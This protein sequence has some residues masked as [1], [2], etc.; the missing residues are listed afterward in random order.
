MPK[1]LNFEDYARAAEEETE[2]YRQQGRLF[3]VKHSP[4]TLCGRCH[5]NPRRPYHAY[6]L[7]CGNQAMR[8]SRRRNGG[9][10]ALPEPEKVKSRC[11]AYTNVLIHRGVLVRQPC[12][13]C[14]NPKSEAHHPDYQKPR[15]VKWL[16]RTCHLE[17]H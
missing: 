9:Y 6:C 3:H 13:K 2:R 7:P 11:R 4:A 10:R 17:G 15:L 12:E 5:Q 16:C 1:I 8:D 14:G